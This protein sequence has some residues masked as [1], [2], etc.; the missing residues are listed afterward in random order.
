LLVLPERVRRFLD[1]RPLIGLIAGGV[2]SLAL[3]VFL[4]VADTSLVL[5]AYERSAES[6]LAAVVIGAGAALGTVLASA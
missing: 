1:G 2:F 4:V 6:A 3:V 5:Q